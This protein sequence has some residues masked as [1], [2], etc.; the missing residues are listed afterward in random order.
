MINT[1]ADPGHIGGN[2]ELPALS[3]LPKGRQPRIVAH[4]NV[5]D[6][7]GGPSTPKQSRLPEALWPNDEYFTPTKDFDFNGEAVIVTTFRM[8]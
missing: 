8:P 4:E 1:D 5:L 7:L 6:R 2:A 3:G